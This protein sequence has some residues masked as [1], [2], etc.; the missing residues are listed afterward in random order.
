MSPELTLAAALVAQ[1]ADDPL[2]QERLLEAALVARNPHLTALAAWRVTQ[3]ILAVPDAPTTGT[4]RRCGAAI[5]DMD[6]AWE[7][8]GGAW[9]CGDAIHEPVPV[10]YDPATEIAAI[11]HEAVER[12]YPTHQWCGTCW[13]AAQQAVTTDPVRTVVRRWRF[14]LGDGRN[15]LAPH[16]SLVYPVLLSDIY[17]GA[18]PPH[19]DGEYVWIAETGYLLPSLV[20]ARRDSHFK[21]H[22]S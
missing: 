11:W 10:A 20:P 5:V 18:D 6:H 3:R 16:R 13:D 15:G 21:E 2:Y 12:I 4:C 14:R 1:T 7:D 17:R 8:G 9:R 19:L 22:R